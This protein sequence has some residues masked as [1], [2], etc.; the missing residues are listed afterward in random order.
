MSGN[1]KSS[2]KIGKK[3]CLSTLPKKGDASECKNHPT[4]A[5][6]PHESKI[7]LR[8]INERLRPQ[9]KRE[10]PAEQ[11]GFI[12]GRGTRD[13]IANIRHIMEKC[14]EFQQKIFLCFIN[15][16]K[17]FHCVRYSALWTALKEMGIPSHLIHSIRNLYDGQAAYIRTGKGIEIVIGLV[18]QGVRQGCILSLSLFNLYAEYII[19]RAVADWPGGLPV[20]GYNDNNLRYADNTTLIAT[21]VADMAELLKNFKVESE[22]LGLRPNVSKTMIMAISPGSVEK[23]LIIDSNKVESVSKFNFLGCLITKDGGC[24]QDIRHRLAMARSAMTNLSKIWADRGI[25]RTTKVT[26]QKQLL[27][28]NAFKCLYSNAGV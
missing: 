9:K 7:L 16:S 21:S 1:H 11:A 14:F 20:G 19:R 2:Q 23:P 12:K 17:V 3:I 26:L 10:L 28:S 24:G 13:Q 27:K 22:L 4:I 5:L 25:T 8:I 15:Y 18:G 6:I